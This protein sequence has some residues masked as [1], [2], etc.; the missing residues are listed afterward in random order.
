MY[1]RFFVTIGNQELIIPKFSIYCL[2]NNGVAI[3]IFE[4]SNENQY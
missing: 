1:N 3:Y 4:L 2:K